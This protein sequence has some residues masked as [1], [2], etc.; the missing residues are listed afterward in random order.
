MKKQFLSLVMALFVCAAFAGFMAPKT[1]LAAGGIGYVSVQQVF[2]SYP[3]ISS[4]RAAV[5][6]ENQKAQK[7]FE[8]KAAA[9]DDK[10]KMELRRTLVE[11]V[12]NREKELVTPIQ[13]KIRAAIKKVAAAQGIA[14]VL[15]EGAVIMGGTDLTKDVIAVVASGK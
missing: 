5:G 3:D 7:E 12:A 13:A 4:V 1:A 2:N 10:G 15:E 8:S 14:T 11:R 9:L 6:L